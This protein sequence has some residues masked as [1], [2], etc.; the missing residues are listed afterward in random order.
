MQFKNPDSLSEAI[1]QTI[2]YADI[3]DYPVTLPEIHRYLIGYGASLPHVREVLNN[4]LLTT[5]KIE[6]D[7]KFYFLAG[8]QDLVPL[9][10]DRASSSAALWAQALRYG[11]WIS[12]L[13]FVRMVAVTGALASSNV[14]QNADL[15]YLIVTEPGYLWLSRAMILALTRLTAPFGATICP[16]YLLTSNVLSLS[17]KDL[18]TAQELIRMVP[19]SGWSI[20][21]QMREL[22]TWADAFLPNALGSP[23][24]KYL[25]EP[26]IILLQRLGERLLNNPLGRQLEAW[27]RKRKIAK[28]SQQINPSPEI[29]FSADRCKGHF[30]QHGR[31]TL[32]I[33]REKVDKIMET[34]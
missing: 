16:N 22:N 24:G 21:K 33:F 27:E 17:E 23:N 2:S 14:D 34:Q 28:L 26:K 6:S 11:R 29:Q 13:P 10:Q 3:F 25:R 12:Q 20:Y 19:I 31:R 30:E 7:G 5:A 1:L 9:R 4:G 15:D 8:K 32:Q 18:F